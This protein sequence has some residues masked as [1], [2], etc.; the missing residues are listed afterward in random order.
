[1]SLQVLASPPPCASPPTSGAAPPGGPPSGTPFEGALAEQLARTAPAEGQQQSQGEGRIAGVQSTPA[2]RG[3]HS[4]RAAAAGAQQAGAQQVS[5]D[6]AP[7]AVADP[8]AQALAGAQVITDT[9]TRLANPAPLPASVLSAARSALTQALVPNSAGAGAGTGATSVA[10]GEAVPAREASSEA[11]GAAALAGQGESSALVPAVARSAQTSTPSSDTAQDSALHATAPEAAPAARAA[12]APS[13]DAQAPASNGPLAG[14]GS[15]RADSSQG[16]STL[17]LATAAASPTAP[18]L[19]A[20]ERLQGTAAAIAAAGPNAT[21][22]QVSDTPVARPG[23]GS[24]SVAGSAAVV[25]LSPSSGAGGQ[26]APQRES[27]AHENARA[28]VA[29]ATRNGGAISSTLPGEAAA[30]GEAPLAGISSTAGEASSASQLPAGFQMQEMIDS[31]HAT[32]ELATRQGITQARIALEPEELGSVRIH[33]SQT[34]DGLLARVTAE[35][36]AA[37]QALATG[38][39]ELHHSLS[40]LGVSLLRLDIGSYGHSQARE[41]GSAFSGAAGQRSAARA[42]AG[43]EENAE[44]SQTA[45]ELDAVTPTV[46]LANGALVD[47]LA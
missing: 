41:Q 6:P 45:V 27:E 46:G 43:A 44:N 9:P 13:A 28:S 18:S 7:G 42:A 29:G 40:S 20:G 22:T 17:Q 38:R 10:S 47:V 35:T 3:A 30:P 33:L 2:R 11:P 23:P 36:P 32:I 19:R 34:A 14:V 1:M 25:G 15:G 16:A 37:A 39:S 26:Q 5:A 12:A 31:I 4:H 24:A 8:Q 21:S